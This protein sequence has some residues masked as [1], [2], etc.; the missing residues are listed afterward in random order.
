MK[1]TKGFFKLGKLGL[2]MML[3]LSI[4]IAGCSKT[5]SS[6]E[7]TASV[8]PNASTAPS[9]TKPQ[10]N[11]VKSVS[12]KFATE[13][14]P[15]EQNNKVVE[16]IVNT[17]NSKQTKVKVELQLVDY[18]ISNNQR[19]WLTTQLIGGTAPDIVHSKYLWSHEDY[20]K[21]LVQ[22]LNQYLDMPNPYYDNK[23]WKT[24]FSNVI[25]KNMIVPTTDKIAGISTFSTVVRIY[26]NKTLFAKAGIT[27]APKTWD[28]FI[29][30][31]AKIKAAGI[32]PMAIG[33]S[34]QGGDRF[35]WILRNLTDQ[36]SEF[37][38]PNLDLDKNGTI[39]SN[40]IVAGVDKGTIDFTKSPWIDILPLLKDW[41]QYWPKGFNGLTAD[42]ATEMFLRGTAAM[43]PNTPPFAK[44]LK[45]VIDYGVMRIP[46][47]TKSNQK[48]AEEKY[49]ELGGNPD[50]V[51]S[52]PTTVPAEKIKAAVDF[53]MY[54]TS[55]EVQLINA[56]QLYQVP[57]LKDANFPE[58]IK[59]FL[60][61][62]E[63]FKMNLFGPA[64]SSKLYEVVGKEGQL[65]LEGTLS[66]A[67]YVK[68]LN[69]AAKSEA[70]ALKQS[71]GWSEANAYGT[72]K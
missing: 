3:V 5:N 28:E 61:V 20:N 6:T 19:T 67:D 41:T 12:I 49:Y 72:K 45:G 42:N 66:L 44:D 46:M 54:L 36:T 11:D 32:T 26:Y 24:T 47:L 40:E 13:K 65:Y 71:Q 14:S 70:A 31:Q 10:T 33:N 55:P 8:A 38:M 4:I 43:T 23:I 69:D 16:S 2:C 51:Y 52:I 62:N 64:F 21:K 1:N 7:P 58:N 48:N 15:I 37:L 59:A 17:Y 34:T 27:E 18:G 29:Q 30:A 68:K 25:T 9:T 39:A 56:E 53:L 57:V 63:P 60:V 50:G 22:E 35:N